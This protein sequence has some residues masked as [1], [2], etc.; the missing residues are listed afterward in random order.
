MKTDLITNSITS[1][2]DEL[3]SDSIP[4]RLQNDLRETPN[5]I[6]CE[7]SVDLGKP[8]LNE[9]GGASHRNIG[10]FSIRIK[11][12]IG[13][14][15]SGLLAI[16]DRIVSV[17]TV[18]K[19]NNI[20]FRVPRII[21]VGRVGEGYQVNVIC[22][23][24]ADSKYLVVVVNLRGS[25]TGIVNVTGYLSVPFRT[26]A[27]VAAASNVDGLLS[28][29]KWL[30]GL[31]TVA[32]NVV[33]SLSVKTGLI[34]S[35]VAV[36]NISGHLKVM[37]STWGQVITTSNIFGSLNIEKWLVSS[38]AA[39]SNA[40]GSLSIETGLI[41]LAAIAS[42]VAG[43]L[44]V[45]ADFIELVGSVEATSNISGSLSVETGLVGSVVAASNVS[46]H[47]K[48]ITPTW[49][50]A[51]AT[52]NVNGSL[53]I[54][55]WLVGPIAATSNI[56]GS[57]NSDK[58]L[59]S[60]IAAT[61]NV[62]G[63][64]SVETGLI[65]S[66]VVTFNIV[67]SLSVKTGLVGSIAATSNVAGS[68]N[69]I[70][71][72]TGSV[73]ATSNVSGSLSVKTG[74]V[75]SV[76]AVSN[77]AGSL[78]VDVGFIEIDGSIAAT[79]NIAGS[80]NVETGLIGSIATTSNVSGLLTVEEFVLLSGSISAVSDVPNNS[81]WWEQPTGVWD[82]GDKW[83]NEHFI[84][85]DSEDSLGSTTLVHPDTWEYPIQLSFPSGPVS[86]VRFLI[87]TLESREADIRCHYYDGS[88]HTANE[89]VV[90]NSDTKS[91]K[92]INFG[93]IKNNVTKISLESRFTGV[94]ICGIWLYDV[95]CYKVIRA[96]NLSVEKGLQG[97]VAAVSTISGSLNWVHLSGSIAATSSVSGS[98]NINKNL[99]GSISVTS[100][101][102]GELTEMAFTSRCS[103]YLSGDQ[104]IVTGTLTKITF[105]SEDYDG[106]GEFD[107]TNN[108][109]VVTTT[110]YYTIHFRIICVTLADQKYGRVQLYKNKGEGSEEILMDTEKTSSVSTRHTVLI[111]SDDVYLEA[112]DEL[113]LWIIHNHGSNRDINGGSLQRSTMSIH[114]FA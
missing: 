105:D 110:G 46:G 60:Y 20:N 96:G 18:V 54:D 24:F 49:G 112:G 8:I 27:I 92:E 23:F 58:W 5:M 59:A 75:G 25:S 88:W 63:L 56:V 44:T 14:G 28:I 40:S 43:S 73:A 16:A 82:A 91:W 22:P 38:I 30:A 17:F 7:A 109:F 107:I 111:C 69:I 77:I 65:G 2:F 98:L 35:V 97:F 6:W 39:T 113:E 108:K 10:N 64:L 47:L 53:N 21:N 19:I 87:A 114:R 80:L 79:S 104:E 74:L 100:N 61:S 42:N 101:L 76:V 51:T 72:A 102:V 34:G 71:L 15:L 78:T 85:D 57:L 90:V 41:G 50:N 99:S 68:L 66:V 29:D 70:K 106:D 67:G 86:K 95:D 52:S 1:Y 26:A 62:A 89:T 13:V 55:K 93:G 45:T 83:N 33:G 37:T 3:F 103:V 4:I 32:L 81:E 9:V 12:N 11:D 36:A 48:V 31:I 94:G 84:I